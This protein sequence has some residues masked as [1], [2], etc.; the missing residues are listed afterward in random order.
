MMFDHSLN[1]TSR[2]IVPTFEI[3]KKSE[4]YPELGP[5]QRDLSW[6]QT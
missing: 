1:H 5:E 6:G 3:N 4:L 2:G